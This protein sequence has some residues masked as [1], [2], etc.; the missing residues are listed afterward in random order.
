MKTSGKMWAYGVQTRLTRA[1]DAPGADMVVRS[2]VD[3]IWR[4]TLN[5]FYALN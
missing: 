3:Y 1:Y 5:R 4:Y 2:H